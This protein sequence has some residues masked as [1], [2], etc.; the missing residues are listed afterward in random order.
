MDKKTLPSFISDGDPKIVNDALAFFLHECSTNM[1]P[2]KDEVAVWAAGLAERGPDFARH[3]DA[4][5]RWVAGD[6]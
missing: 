4:C 3:A 5:R 6:R 2:S 1:I